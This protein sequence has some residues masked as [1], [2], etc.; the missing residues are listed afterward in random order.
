M[1]KLFSI[2]II[3]ECDD[4]IEKYIIDFNVPDTYTILPA[5]NIQ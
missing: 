1:S 3:N 5:T 4:K 2:K